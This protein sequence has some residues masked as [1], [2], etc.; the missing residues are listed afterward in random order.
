MLLYSIFEKPCAVSGAKI[1]HR[2]EL[3]T[4]PEFRRKNTIFARQT[5]CHPDAQRKDLRLLPG[6]P[7]WRNF[8]IAH[9]TP[10]MP[11][12]SPCQSHAMPSETCEATISSGMDRYSV[13]W[14]KVRFRFYSVIPVGFLI[15]AFNVMVVFTK[16]RLPF[17]YL[18]LFGIEPIFLAV[19][20][21]R[22]FR[23]ACPRCG[24]VFSVSWKTVLRNFPRFC[25]V[26]CGLQLGAKDV[27]VE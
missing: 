24:N 22:I 12:R 11:Q 8:R 25:C 21:V 19:L 1:R 9:Y 16:P 3:P 5:N 13:V 27:P 4:T 7:E 17:L 23:F 20:V 10:A 2:E 15:A 26:S 6:V 14:R 18:A